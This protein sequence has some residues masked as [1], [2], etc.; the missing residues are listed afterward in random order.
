MRLT[1][2]RRKLF[3]FQVSA[4][5]AR[6]IVFAAGMLTAT[7]GLVACDG[8]PFGGE[9]QAQE[10]FFFEE[11]A[12]GLN[13]VWLDGI[14]GNITV[15]GVSGSQTVAVG[16]FRRVRSSSL[17]DA[18]EQL[19]LLEVVVTTIGDVLVIRTEQ[20]Q[21]TQGRTYEV[22]Y[23]L[24][25]PRRLEVEVDN[26]NG[27]ISVSTLDD[28]VDVED[29]NGNIT[30]RDIVGNASVTTVNGNVDAEVTMPLGGEIG[31]RSTNGN[32]DLDIPQ[33]T[34]AALLASLANGSITTSGLSIDDAQSTPT[35][36]TGVL[37]AGDGEIELQTTNGNIVIRGF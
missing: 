25:V 15:V 20:P 5:S 33:N 21:E 26:V 13:D 22:Q 12:T 4:S 32:L 2:L 31:L 11:D 30:L 9:E 6:R 29:T 19:E 27:N 7:F 28:D 3:R 37:G 16:G 36:L 18:E 14:N 35:S 23:D 8:N 17:A 24:T 1:S 10:E 34:S